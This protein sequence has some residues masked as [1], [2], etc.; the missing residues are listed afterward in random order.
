MQ[1]VPS[2]SMPGREEKKRDSGESLWTSWLILGVGESSE[3]TL[4]TGVSCMARMT[5]PS[6]S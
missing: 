2:G 6:D 1:D 5:G 3:L 4:I